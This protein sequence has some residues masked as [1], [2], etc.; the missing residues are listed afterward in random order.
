M[1]NR[2][3]MA[4]I[5]SVMILP[6]FAQQAEGDVVHKISY[7]AS[8]EKYLDYFEKKN[9]ESKMIKYHLNGKIAEI[10]FFVNELRTGVWTQ[11]DE[12]GNKIAEAKFNNGK[13]DGNWM[14]WNEK[15]NL[16]IQIDYENGEKL[17]AKSF[18]VNGNIT[19]TQKP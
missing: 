1:L 12:N 19:S 13:K 8:G 7:Y 4:V 6:I 10:G 3:F 11:F 15:G 16:L 14:V 2:V 9:T 5:T 17:A 18:D